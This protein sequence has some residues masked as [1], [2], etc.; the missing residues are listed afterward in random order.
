[1]A[2][3]VDTPNGTRFVHDHDSIPA[4]PCAARP[5]HH[6]HTNNLLALQAYFAC[7]TVHHSCTGVSLT[8]ITDNNPLFNRANGS[9]VGKINR[10]FRTWSGPLSD[11]TR[12]DLAKN[13]LRGLYNFLYLAANDPHPYA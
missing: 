10:Y 13:D 7:G 3:V 4:L 9:Y 2:T 8:K 1:M 5:T 6:L 11:Q 12:D